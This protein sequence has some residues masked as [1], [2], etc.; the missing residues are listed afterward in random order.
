MHFCGHGNMGF[1][2]IGTGLR[3]ENA[4][5]SQ[6]LAEWM[7]PDGPG[8]VLHGCWVASAGKLGKDGRMISHDADKRPSELGTFYPGRPGAISR[9]WELLWQLSLALLVPVKAGIDVQIG[10]KYFETEGPTLMVTPNGYTYD[11]A[12]W[13]KRGQKR[14]YP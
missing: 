9:G 11:D 14:N 2:E 1:M 3:S 12:T 10:D 6:P 4:H 8:V 13:R 7:T 5:F